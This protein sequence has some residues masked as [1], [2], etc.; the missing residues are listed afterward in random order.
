MTFN[1][2]DGSVDKRYCLTTE[3]RGGFCYAIMVNDNYTTEEIYYD[4]IEYDTS[5]RIGEPHID[6][7]REVRVL[8]REK[9]VLGQDGHRA[10]VG[11]IVEVVKGRKYPKGMK[12]SVVRVIEGHFNNRY[13]HY[14]KSC[15]M[16]GS[17]NGYE[18]IDSD[19]VRIIAI[20]GGS[21]NQE[22]YN[23]VHS[24]SYCTYKGVVA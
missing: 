4:D 1:Y 14:V 16:F 6:C 3:C 2:Y 23:D 22:E 21:K 12:M 10:D 7:P 20:K 15:V 18:S 9:A 5:R 11:D 19:N 17:E 13:G 8:V 24:V